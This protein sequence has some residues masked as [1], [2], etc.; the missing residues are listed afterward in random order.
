MNLKYNFKY[1]ILV[2]MILII[3]GCNT[4]TPVIDVP[5]ENT[6]ESIDNQTNEL[7]T[8]NDPRLQGCDKLPL[9]EKGLAISYPRY[10][11]YIDIAVQEKEVK[12]CDYIDTDFKYECYSTVGIEVGDISICNKLQTQLSKEVC[13]KGVARTTSDFSKCKLIERD[14]TEDQCYL[15]ISYTSLNIE[16]CEN[17]KGKSGTFYAECIKNIA[18][19][20]EDE[21]IC[22]DIAWDKIKD[23]CFLGLKSC[24]KI[25]DPDLNQK[26]LS[27]EVDLSECENADNLDVCMF[28]IAKDVLNSNVCSR[29]ANSALKYEC[30]RNIAVDT[31]DS[32]ICDNMQLG[33]GVKETAVE[34]SISRCNADVESGNKDSTF[35]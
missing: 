35:Y 5:K 19:N 34:R 14:T 29:I 21:T 24:S 23:E 17:I 27:F 30:Y 26:C 16:L 4:Q 25:T 28:N 8:N 6:Q 13:Y 3:I 10:N 33:N 22:E 12:I 11:C 7:P 31:Q 15:G 32:S 18:I 9:I 1:G 20:N 2:I